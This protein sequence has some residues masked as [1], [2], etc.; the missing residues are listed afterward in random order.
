MLP[1]N[2]S[3]G[4]QPVSSAPLGESAPQGP[5][6]HEP[7]RTDAGTNAVAPGTLGLGEATANARV[8]P[9]EQR[10][11]PPSNEER[12]ISQTKEGFIRRLISS[13][14]SSSARAVKAS[15][16]WI[17]QMK[18]RLSKTPAT[19]VLVNTAAVNAPQPPLMERLERF[20]N[21]I[22][23]S[24]PVGT[25]ANK[26]EKLLL[27]IHQ[28]VTSLT[29]KNSLGLLDYRAND[30][31]EILTKLDNAKDFVVKDNDLSDEQKDTYLSY[32]SS[33]RFNVSRSV[34]APDKE[35]R[36][37]F[38]DDINKSK[39][40]LEKG[41]NETEKSLSEI[42]QSLISLIDKKPPD[43]GDYNKMLDTLKNT[44]TSILASISENKS[45]TTEQQ[46]NYLKYIDLQS[47]NISSCI[48]EL[49]K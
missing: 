12:E 27:N 2:N 46:E 16:N 31:N 42:H 8:I 33:L 49:N 5:K 38:L 1:T 40:I 25:P 10:V 3:S 39:P 4:L 29:K 21:A 34:Q 48:R 43:V 26:A 24:E 45:L 18:A 44:R 30:Y 7:S 14:K 32:I 37:R 9:A 23:L 19:P 22:R 15:A 17:A 20:Q 36:E 35:S 11:A 28:S 47:W 13:F 41:L 6:S